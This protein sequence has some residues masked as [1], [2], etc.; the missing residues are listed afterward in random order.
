M[1]IPLRIK[2]G[3][4]MWTVRQRSRKEM[5]EDNGLC[6]PDQ[7]E[8]WLYRGLKRSVKREKLLHEVLHACTDPACYDK[9]VSDE[10]FVTTVS[11]ALLQVLQDNPDLVTYLTA[12]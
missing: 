8:I 5:G 3:P 1:K 4:H 6:L 12:V 9:I 10:V 7:T 11:P 2:I